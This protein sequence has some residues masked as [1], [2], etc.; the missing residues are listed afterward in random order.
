MIECEKKKTNSQVYAREFMI[1]KKIKFF[2]FVRLRRVHDRY[3][4]KSRKNFNV[5]LFEYNIREA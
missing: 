4:N 1:P 5:Y 2:L 3:F